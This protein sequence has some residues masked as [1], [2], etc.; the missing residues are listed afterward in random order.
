MELNTHIYALILFILFY[1]V[2]V[3]K[4]FGLSCGHL[5]CDFFEHKNKTVITTCLNHSMALKSFNFCLKHT[6][7]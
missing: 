4:G 1:F 5:R 6:A 7:E 3:T 2:T